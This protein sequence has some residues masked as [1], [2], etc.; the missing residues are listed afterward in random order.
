MTAKFADGTEMKEPYS[1]D[2]L[3]D[4]RDQAI[5]LKLLPCWRSKGHCIIGE[6]EMY[7]HDGGWKVFD[8]GL[9]QW[10]YYTCDKCGYAWSLRKI[11]RR[12]DNVE[13][14]GTDS[15]I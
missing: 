3:E 14:K 5:R 10:I 2:D 13:N 1:M 15:K 12:L 8:M 7:A 11:L 4:V 6:V 9:K